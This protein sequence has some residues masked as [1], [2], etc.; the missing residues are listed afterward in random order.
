MWISRALLILCTVSCMVVSGYGAEQ[1]TPGKL[2]IMVVDSYHREYLWTQYTHDG[3]SAGMRKYGYFD[4]DRQ[5]AQF[6]KNDHAESSKAIFRMLWLDT[7]REKS[8]QQIAQN[9]IRLAGLIRHFH[10]D[11]LFLGDD[12]A[13]NYIGNQFL[14]TDIPIVFWGVN[15]TPLKYGLVE[16]MTRPGHNV[17]GVYQ[18]M[19]FREN[20]QLLKN[21]VPQAK[22]FAILSDDSETGR[23][24]AK[25][26]EYLARKGELPL[27]LT[28]TFATENFEAWKQKVLELQK[29]VDAFY[30][31]Q[32][33]SFKDKAGNYVAPEVAVRWYLTHSN[34]PEA[35]PES[36][37]VVQG[38]LCTADDSG[39]NQGFEAAVIGHDIL[40]RGAS[41]ATF[42]PR[43]PRRGQLIVNRQR[44]GML[45]ITLTKSMGIEQY[46]E[47]AS[48]LKGAGK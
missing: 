24:N 21:L 39:Y 14:D 3:F 6:K 22:T 9:T 30:I 42:P 20:L 10:P 4:N 46:I 11:I 28:E 47:E 2:K 18:A 38:I 34:I 31:A 27:R 32:Y 13:A 37:F 35:M 44:A 36:Q 8:K 5:I 16:S 17:T 33:A 7:K 15:N 29:K 12:N 43:A 23:S 48:V 26:L 40:A 25:A 19:Y 1:K 41:P 45:G